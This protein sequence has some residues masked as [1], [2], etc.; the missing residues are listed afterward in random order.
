MY[1]LDL[2]VSETHMS[3]I[4]TRIR[5]Q[6]RFYRVH[7]KYTRVSSRIQV[8]IRLHGN[9]AHVLG[10]PT[11]QPDPTSIVHDLGSS[12]A[13]LHPLHATLGSRQGCNLGSPGLCRH[14][15][16]CRNFSR[17]RN[18]SWSRIPIGTRS[19]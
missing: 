6:T 14:P 3:L 19:P 1:G 4:W 12:Q 15:T 18:L 17:G 2:Y 5:V 7:T 13:I 8:R 11:T 10:H 16:S 9:L